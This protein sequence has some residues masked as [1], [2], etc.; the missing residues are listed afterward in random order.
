MQ[1][2][3]KKETETGEKLKTNNQINTLIQSEQN[4]KKAIHLVI[5]MRL[6]KPTMK[7]QEICN[8]LDQHTGFFSCVQ[9]VLYYLSFCSR[10]GRFKRKKL[11]IFSLLQNQR[12]FLIISGKIMKVYYTTRSEVLK[13]EYG[14]KPF[15]FCFFERWGN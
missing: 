4:L 9:S 8:L 12:I 3:L 11:Q 2:L 15:Q 5:F 6:Q 10:N 14:P 13:L 7:S 1:N